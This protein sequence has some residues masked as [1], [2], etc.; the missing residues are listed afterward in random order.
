AEMKRVD[1]EMGGIVNAVSN[2]LVQAEV[3]KQALAYEQKIQRG[4]MV[5]VGVNKYRTED[6]RVSQ[7]VELH[8]YKPAAT[9]EQLQR[10]AQVKAE[11]DA[12]AVDAALARVRDDARGGVNLMPAMLQ[13]V[14]AYATVGE[15]TIVLKEVFGEFKEPVKW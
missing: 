15:I 13:A 12:N 6:G 11:R 8:E 14:R 1:D 5:K 3:A 9:E 7:E 4:E 10:L 2:G